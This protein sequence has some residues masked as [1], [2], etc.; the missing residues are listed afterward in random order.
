M[1]DNTRLAA[2]G[3]IATKHPDPEKRERARQLVYKM[4]GQEAPPRRDV[5]PTP[6]AQANPSAPEPSPMLYGTPMH[7][8]GRGEPDR[9]RAGQMLAP[10]I[11]HKPPIDWN[12][13]AKR[14]QQLATFGDATTFGL[15]TK[16]ATALG[17]PDFTDEQ[18][19][20]DAAQAPMSSGERAGLTAAGM[21]V[22]GPRALA[23]GAE[24]LVVPR[25]AGL[26]AKAPKTAA[27][28]SGG[29]TSSLAAGADAALRAKFSG[30][31][32]MESAGAGVDAATDPL[33]VAAG[34]ALGRLF[35][36]GVRMRA[37]N[38]NVNTLEEAGARVGPLTPGKGGLLDDPMVAQGIDPITGRVSEF[39]RGK[40]AR[41]AARRAD[42]ALTGRTRAIDDQMKA[43]KGEL[44]ASG[45][46][47]KA[48]EIDDL[49][50]RAHEMADD[51]FLPKDVRKTVRGE[52]IEE[53]IDRFG[54]VD[55]AGKFV[56]P[57]EAA[58]RLRKKIFDLADIVNPKSTDPNLKQLGG[59]AKDAVDGSA[60]GKI[61]A[62]YRAEAEKIQ[63]ARRA[64][65]FP[66][67]DDIH[68][69][70]ATPADEVRVGQ[71]LSRMGQDTA[72]AGMQD[73]PELHQAVR[74]FPELEPLTK[75]VPALDARSKLEFKGL[76][77][78]P[79]GG[80]YS[81][82]GSIVGDNFEAGK[83]RLIAPA[84]IGAG[85]RA[86]LAGSILEQI[87]RGA[88]RSEERKKRE[89]GK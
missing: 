32:S 17:A 48:I 62:P 36:G 66:Q 25:L 12:N 30:R 22:G 33:N 88:K 50:Q 26:A 82:L 70:L 39:G 80:L 18:R 1:D 83:A 34:A 29:M 56:M 84:M 64:L 60:F 35:G 10:G 38:P 55:D 87:S 49:V 89:G 2:L 86:P 72:R 21:M 58:N 63:S 85:R 44:R 52:V 11:E 8:G 78:I 3:E 37:S 68:A 65:E 54:S 71:A 45:E 23:V 53:I 46:A 5:G 76:S 57:A 4:Q 7:T 77:H 81:K 69:P 13:P 59:V 75:A 67:A 41:S 43:A 28:V 9:N 61:N 79:T 47:D 15:G 73:V 42:E 16:I 19:K 6:G 14:R 31:S 20:K 51:P 40:V 24:R 27:A 74:D